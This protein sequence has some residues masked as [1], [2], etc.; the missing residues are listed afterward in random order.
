MTQVSVSHE[1]QLRQAMAE[2]QALREQLR[3]AQRLATMGTMTA[4]VAHEFNNILTPIINYAQMAQS[5]PKLADKAI[6]KAADGGQRASLIC[7]ALLGMTHDSP[8]CEAV[9]VAGLVRDTLAAMARDLAKDCIDL[10]MAVPEDLSVDAR[11]VELQQVML[12]LIMNARSAV[13][14]RTGSRCIRIEAARH[15]DA[16]EIHVGDNGC[17]IDPEVLPRIFEPFF[18]TKSIEADDGGH[19]LGLTICQEIVAS[20]NGQISVHS[21]AGQGARFTVRLPA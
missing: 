11:K 21:Q 7:K 3:R 15:A 12:N 6:A 8:T 14:A 13:I 10:E 2:V 18:S 20:M 9:N 19:G 16:V 5:N 1:E 4:M 17:G